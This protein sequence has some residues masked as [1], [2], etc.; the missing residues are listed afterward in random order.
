MSAVSRLLTLVEDDGVWPAE[1]L[2]AF[3]AMIPKAAGGSRPQDQRPITV[4]DVLYRIWSKGVVLT[5]GPTLHG[6]YLGTAAMGFRA[7]SGT[8]HA[9]QLLSDVIALR[10]RQSAPLW[11]ASFD[12]EKC[13]DSLP[14]WALFR[15]LA[16]TG[17]PTPVVAAFESFY[18][19]LRRRFRYGQ[20]DG[21]I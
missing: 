7:E 11:L 4:L 19:H 1:W 3:V 13:F 2:D 20:V 6:Q 10:R 9:A 14:W 17:I 12:I 5:W 15:I 8:L 18:R 16:H 21:V